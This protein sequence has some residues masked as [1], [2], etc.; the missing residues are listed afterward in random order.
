VGFFR[1][2]LISGEKVGY[3]AGKLF[4]HQEKLFVSKE[5]HAFPKKVR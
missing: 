3:A 1:K 4:Y 5:K 2:E